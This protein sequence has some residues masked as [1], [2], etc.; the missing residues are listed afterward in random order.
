[1]K[2]IVAFKNHRNIASDGKA[3]YP[4]PAEGQP[5]N[6]PRYLGGKPAEDGDAREPTVDGTKTW[7]EGWYLWTS[8]SRLAIHEK[9]DTMLMDL[10]QQRR[11]SEHW[12][13]RREVWQDYQDHLQNA[14][15]NQEGEESH[16]RQP[17]RWW[18]PI[19]P[20][21]PVPEFRYVTLQIDCMFI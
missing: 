18:G 1:M 14:P 20:L 17:S 8:H 7:D 10:E 13:Q 16:N 9:T 6:I 2:N 19:V 5:T 15:H 21:R 4:L 12:E 3:K 11:L